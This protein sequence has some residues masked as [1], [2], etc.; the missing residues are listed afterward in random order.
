MNGESQTVEFKTKWKDDYLKT[1]AAFANTSGGVIKIGVDDTGEFID[2]KDAGKLMEKLPNTVRN[3]LDI[4]PS[5]NIEEKD[6][7]KAVV[8]SI[9]PSSMPISYNERYYMRSGSTTLELNGKNLADFLMMKQGKTWDDDIEERAGSED[10][11]PETVEKFQNYARERLPLLAMEKDHMQALEKLHLFENGKLK[12]AAVLLF[13][14]DPACF[15][16]QAHLKIGRFKSITELTATDMVDGNLFRQVENTFDILSSRYI[17]YRTVFDG[18]R[19]EDIPDYPMDALREAVINAIIHRDYLGTS[20][21]QIRVYDDR[22]VVMNE[23]RFPPEVPV[24]KLKTEHISRP[25]NPDLAKV[26][27]FAGFIESWG[28]GTLKMVE[29][30]LE[31]G[32]PEPEFIEENGVIKTVFRRD[33]F[34]EDYLKGMGLSGRQI[35]AVMYAK[36][37]GKIT[38]RE[39]R[40]ITGLSDEGARTDINQILG[41]GLFEAK[42]KGRGV[43]YVLRYAGD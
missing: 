30:C 13:G 25:H 11:D 24:E 7:K 43:H 17:S 4:V 32:L 37:R 22:L 6:G 1:V 39:Y 20:A 34:S 31:S 42:G 38:N 33:I 28:R 23:G 15:Y 19:R 41:K 29:M 27:Y 36:E 10:I 3:K 26:F 9:S 18:I 40:E 12:R 5:V 8:L 21:V 16:P 35:K 2:L 14:K